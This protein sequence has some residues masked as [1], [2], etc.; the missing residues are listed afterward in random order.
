MKTQ[1]IINYKESVSE[2]QYV[3]SGGAQVSIWA[4]VVQNLYESHGFRT[5]TCT[6][7]TGQNIVQL[8]QLTVK[9]GHRSYSN[10]MSEK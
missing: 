6:M 2:L 3:M 4:I 1:H 10:V 7:I 8:K 9:N 5:L